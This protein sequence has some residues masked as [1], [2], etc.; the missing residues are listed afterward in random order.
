MPIL[1]NTQFWP[2]P[3]WVQWIALYVWWIATVVAF[4]FAGFAIWLGVF[5][6]Y[7]S[8]WVISAGFSAGSWA[9]GRVVLFLLTGR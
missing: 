4:A 2:R 3:N 6:P 7:R 9:T 1:P 5:S 8:N